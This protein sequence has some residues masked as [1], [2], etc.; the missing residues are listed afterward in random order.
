MKTVQSQD[1]TTIAFD[2]S[3]DGPALILVAGALGVRTHFMVVALADL[4]ATHFTV[5]NYDRRGRGDSGDTQ[6]YAVQREIEDIEALIDEAGGS[7]YVYGVSSGAALA[8]EAASALPDKIKKL[9]LYE[10][11]YVLDGSRPPLPDRYVETVTEFAATGR[12]GD[13]VALFMT[14]VGVPEAFIP[15]MKAD[16]S[17]AEMEAVAHTLAYDGMIMGDNMSGKMFPDD[18]IQRWSSAVSPTLVMAGGNSEPFFRHT[19]DVLAR[20]LPHARFEVVPGQDHAIDSAVLARY[21]IE[22]FGA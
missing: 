1:G 12:R 8:L 7:A 10:P 15:Q 19:G 6:P 2:Q 3:G 21:L 14:V 17:W 20:V 22:F 9:V 16:P 11:P 5:Y 18:V 13:A 4:L